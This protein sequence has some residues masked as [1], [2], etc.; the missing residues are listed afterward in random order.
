MNS[1]RQI[2]AIIVTALFML[3]NLYYIGQ[4]NQ[5]RQN[6]LEAKEMARESEQYQVQVMNITMY[7]PSSVGSISGHDFFGD[8]SR[9]YTGEKVVAG[10][11]AAAGPNIPVGTEIYVEGIGWRRV[12]D[13]GSAIGPNDIDLAVSTKEEAIKFGRQQRLV[14][15]KLK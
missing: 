3:M 9:T 13:R 11:T 4:L 7:A 12:N 14:I 8:P 6:V 2:V 10:E 15:L 5:A 1:W